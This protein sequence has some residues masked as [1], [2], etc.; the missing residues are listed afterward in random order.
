MTADFTHPGRETARDWAAAGPKR[1]LID[2]QWVEAQSGRTL[3]SLNPTTGKLLA[4]ISEA[5]AG[6]VDVAV[7]A[8]RRAFEAPTWSGISPH[9]RTRMLLEMAEAI[10]RHAAELAA[11]E[12][13]D[14]GMPTWFSNAVI[15]MVGDT[16]RYYAGWCSKIFGTT[17]PTDASMFIFTLRD[18]VGVCGQIIPWNV[19]SLMAALKI[20]TALACGNTVVLKPSE[21]ASLSTLRMAELIQDTDLPPGVLNVVTGYGSTV[22][23][24]ISGHPEVDKVAFTGSTVVGKQILQASIETMKRVTLELGGKSPNI[25]FA[26]ADLDKAVVAAVNGFTRNSGQVCSAG[27]RVFVQEGIHD[28]VAGRIVEIASGQKVGDPFDPETKLGP[29]ISA[30]QLDR[31]MSYVDAG[32]AE[33]AEL[34]T[35]GDRV[36]GPGFFVRPTVF[37]GVTNGMRIAR[38]EIFGPVVSLIPFKDEDDAIFKANDTSYGLAA[39]VWSRDI[40]RAHKVARAMK[41]G[42]IWVNTFGET[43]PVMPFGG[44]KQSGLGREFGAESVLAYTESKSVQVR[45]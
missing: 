1:N 11:L 26:D 25:I 6:D 28:E 16:F 27:T 35:G 15:A 30:R 31:V 29:V 39:A 5:D 4:R 37:A 34:R 7:R 2:G 9:L 19:P 18:P 40:S 45:F 13:L 10:D 41:A 33:G 36:E 21:L 38:E 12:T 32:N 3:E 22:G 43:D 44:F 24:A 14:N 42:R 17:T 23:A 8:A 20:A